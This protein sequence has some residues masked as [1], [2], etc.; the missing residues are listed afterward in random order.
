[1]KKIL[2]PVNMIMVVVFAV[3]FIG[4]C[5]SSRSG[6]VYSRHDARQVHVVEMGVVESVKWVY[7]EGT[8]SPFGILAGAI[9]GGVL[10]STIGGGSGRTVATT[11]GAVA[12]GAA[13][14]AIE[15]NATGRDGLEI[16]VSLDSG[17]T[18]VIVQEADMDIQPGD[19]VKVLTARDGSARVSR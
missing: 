8:K 12:G 2:I 1:M 7:I 13:G 6:Q 3:V 10:G 17:E 5:A 11:L 16:V 18:I 19:R 9:I 4:G 15:E 14:S